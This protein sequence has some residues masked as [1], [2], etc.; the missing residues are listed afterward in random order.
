MDHLPRVYAHTTCS[1]HALRRLSVMTN[2]QFE[3]SVPNGKKHKPQPKPILVSECLSTSQHICILGLPTPVSLEQ[4]P[5]TGS[6]FVATG[7]YSGAILGVDIEVDPQTR[8]A[9]VV[10]ERTAKVCRIQESGEPVELA[11]HHVVTAD[12]GSP[13]A[14]SMP[15]GE[16][17]PSA[18]S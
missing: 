7:E 14:F 1:K 8:I 10:K 3:R 2:T 16:P 4:D 18:L 5:E 6:W 15:I 17:S 12:V 13:T 9:R 11:Y